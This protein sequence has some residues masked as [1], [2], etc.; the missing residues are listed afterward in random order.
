M[1]AEDRALV[2]TTAIIRS[3]RELPAAR[4]SALVESALRGAI[5]RPAA[6]HAPIPF[7][8]ARRAKA[9]WIVAAVS[10]VVAAAAVL[11]LFL[12]PAPRPT[13]AA[14]PAPATAHVQLPESWVSRPA[15][16]LVGVIPQAR[17]GEAA[18]R[19]DAI[20]ADRLDGYRERTLARGGR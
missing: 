17:A 8:R 20:F 7:D 5:D 14:T 11:I 12:R 1:S 13:P 6:A 9:P 4:A 15:D 3:A 18:A 10:T 2:E 16:D 19:I